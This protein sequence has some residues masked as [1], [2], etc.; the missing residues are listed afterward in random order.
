LICQQVQVKMSVTLRLSDL[1]LLFKQDPE[2]I[3]VLG[4]QCGDVG[5]PPGKSNA[6][7]G[8]AIIQHYMQG[9]PD[10]LYTVWDASCVE[11]Q[12]MVNYI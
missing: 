3:A 10:Q 2:L 5:L 11:L 8:L 12:V 7:Y 4:G 6:A 1:H 9:R